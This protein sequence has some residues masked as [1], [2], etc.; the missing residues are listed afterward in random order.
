MPSANMGKMSSKKTGL[1]RYVKRGQ[2][3]ADIRKIS[4]HG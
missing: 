1:R 4:R 2:V 3:W